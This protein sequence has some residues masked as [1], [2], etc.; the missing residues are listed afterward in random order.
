MAQVTQVAEVAQ[1]AEVTQVEQ[2]ALVA[3][4]TQVAQVAALNNM[5]DAMQKECKE[6]LQ[7]KQ[8]V[9]I[10]EMIDIVSKYMDLFKKM[11]DSDTTLELERVRTRIKYTQHIFNIAIKDNIN[12]RFVHN[13]K[14]L[15][16]SIY[17]EDFWYLKN[18]EP[19]FKANND[20]GNK[21]ML[22]LLYETCR[23]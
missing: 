1:V 22:V 18:F 3:E 5:L 19:K 11:T 13:F 15:I 9:L 4:V 21:A 6:N 20:E 2:V 14:Q 7:K 17:N 16:M 8:E 23:R 12:E 10:K